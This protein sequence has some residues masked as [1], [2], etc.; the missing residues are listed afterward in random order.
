MENQIFG[1]LDFTQDLKKNLERFSGVGGKDTTSEIFEFIER[2]KEIKDRKMA[3]ER[4]EKGEHVGNQKQAVILN[5]IDKESL[6]I[7]SNFFEVDNLKFETMAQYKALL[8]KDAFKHD[9]I[10]RN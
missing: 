6:K 4:M 10:R 7:N 9:Q 3:K 2:Q 5:A 1:K 8:A